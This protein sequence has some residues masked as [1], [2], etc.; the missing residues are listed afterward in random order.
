M[1]SIQCSFQQ[2]VSHSLSP[3]SKAHNT[4]QG[5]FWGTQ[6]LCMAHNLCKQELNCTHLS[7]EAQECHHIDNIVLQRDL[8]ES[9]PKDIEVQHLS[10]LF[11]FWWKHTPHFQILLYLTNAATNWPTLS[12]AFSN[13]RLEICSD[14]NPISAS[15][16]LSLYRLWQTFLTKMFGPIFF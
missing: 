15:E 10:V 2:V 7:P 5:Y 14:W 11:G 12:G 8:F 1:H 13:K 9:L 6:Q 3:A 16:T 4:F